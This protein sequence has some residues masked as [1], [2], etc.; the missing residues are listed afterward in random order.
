MSDLNHYYTNKERV[1][2]PMLS[3]KK[4]DYYAVLGVLRDATQ[5]EIKRAYLQSAQRLHPDK[6]TAAGETEMFLGVQQAFEI[7]SNPA[8]R[9]Q[10]DATL[11]A[12]EQSVPALTH[13]IY[14]SRLNLVR[15]NEPQLMYALLE[16]EP[17]SQSG[18]FP[19]PPLNFCL[20]I[21]RSTSMQGPKMDLVK[22]SVEQIIRLLRPEDI[23]GVVSFSDRAEVVI[24]SAR[25]TEPARMEARLRLMQSSG[26]TEIYQGLK[27]GFD[28]VQRNYSAAHVNHIVLITDGHTYGDE[29]ACLELAEQAAGLNIGITCMGLGSDWNDILLDS[30]ATATGSNSAY[31]AQPDDIQKIIVRKF[32]SLANIFA[33]D[34]V[35]EYKP[36]DDS[37]INYAFRLQPNVGPLSTESPLHLGIVLQDQSLNVLFE[38]LVQPPGNQMDS[39]ILIDGSLKVTIAARPT[40]V[41]PIRLRLTRDFETDPAPEPPPDIIL[42]ALSRL[43]L[44]RMQERARIDIAD[45]HYDAA[46]SR[47]QTL[48]THL[49]S[50]GEHSLASTV[51]LE[52]E[53]LRQSQNIS[54]EGSKDIKYKTRALLLSAPQEKQK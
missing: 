43:R 8:R 23:F 48:A 32:E 28:E 14:F 21:D 3:N 53:N 50:Q 33:D 49:L 29:R 5:E 17:P 16:L 4:P 18:S 9:A 7:L 34:I 41:P 10:Y 11:P 6:N 13:K 54:S 37:R 15:I 22:S 26:G 52:V 36:N 2:L 30:I 38:F 51:L 46:T 47:L 31:I 12:E 42:S 19:A 39:A 20:V 1:L 45:G 44:Y 24:P 25:I 40:P 27:A 35:L